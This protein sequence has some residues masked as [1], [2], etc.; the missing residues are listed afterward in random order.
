MFIAW[1]K[2]NNK[3]PIAHHYIVL[4][5]VMSHYIILYLFYLQTEPK[6]WSEA[7]LFKNYNC[8]IIRIFKNYIF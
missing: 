2:T 5:Y 3:K 6:E 7:A 4:H 8:T 1:Q